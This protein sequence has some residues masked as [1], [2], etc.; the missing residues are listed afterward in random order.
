MTI[1]DNMY[2]KM[3]YSKKI[4][5]MKIEEGYLVNKKVLNMIVEDHLVIRIYEYLIRFYDFIC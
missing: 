3:F 5:N 4:L 1:E 2:L